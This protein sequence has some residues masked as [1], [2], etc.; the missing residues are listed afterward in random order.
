MMR[1]LVIHATKTAIHC[2]EIEKLKKNF[3]TSFSINDVEKP[4]QI[5]L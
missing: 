5:L 1:F 2:C 4:Q 3:D